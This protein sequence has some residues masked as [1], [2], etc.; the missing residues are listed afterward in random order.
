MISN[1][2]Q[3]RQ[4]QTRLPMAGIAFFAIGI[5]LLGTI[6]STATG[7]D[8][9]KQRQHQP[10]LQLQQQ[11]QH[12]QYQ[13]Q[14]HNR[15]RQ[16]NENKNKTTKRRRLVLSETECTLYL[17]LT[18]YYYGAIV[19]DDLNDNDSSH[20]D[21]HE[22]TWTCEMP[23]PVFNNTAANTA[24]ANANDNVNSTALPSIIPMVLVDIQGLDHH[25]FET[26]GA[27][28]GITTMRVSESYLLGSDVLDT[29]TAN[30]ANEN[31]N[32]VANANSTSTS[33][34]VLTTST[35]MFVPPE[36]IVELKDSQ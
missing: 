33:S 22:E 5:V 35:T 15:Q 16:R 27:K 30:D 11:R 34:A 12:H 2:E 32:D 13:Y 17:R 36:A 8:Y 4:R 28:S 19:D 26:H 29:A 7:L 23:M 6:A 20:E 3:R 25:F 9:T 1:Q 18:E 14:D 24:D 10:Q 31:G 21:N